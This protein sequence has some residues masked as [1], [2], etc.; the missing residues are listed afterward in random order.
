MSKRSV[1][2]SVLIRSGK[3]LFCAM[4]LVF[5]VGAD[6]T[7]LQGDV[8]DTLNRLHY[9]GETMREYYLF[10]THS[11]GVVVSRK[12]GKSLTQWQTK[13]TG[14]D[15]TEFTWGDPSHWPSLPGKP[16]V[17]EER[18]VRH[19]CAGG[20]DFVWVDAYRNDYANSDKHARFKIMTSRAEF[21][22]GTGPWIDITA[23]G[24]CG[25]IGQPYALNEVTTD[26]YSL[27]V[28][29]NIF[30]ADGVTVGKRFFWQH[31]MA[32][33]PRVSNPCW[34]TDKVSVRSA[35]QHHEA[36]WD[37]QKGWSQGA[38]SMDKS[39]TPDG[40]SVTLGRWSMIGKGAGI[41]WAASLGRSGAI[42]DA[43]TATV[44]HS[45]PGA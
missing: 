25:A 31:S 19:N 18:A 45:E 40:V 24:S 5:I 34:K 44:R 26:E 28:W 14:T 35:I 17:V 27:R 11:T 21:R 20:R 7:D 23:G 30:K 2:R 16:I 33:I 3:A 39:G 43:C 37:D 12:T 42:A 38:G 32:Y 4:A 13:P 22:V 29:G 9:N 41:G 36:W 10:G 15:T 1:K 8:T 6:A